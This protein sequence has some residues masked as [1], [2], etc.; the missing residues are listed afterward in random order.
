MRDVRT[1]RFLKGANII[2]KYDGAATQLRR[3]HLHKRDVKLLPTIEKH[4]INR[5]VDIGERFCRVA[6]AHVD[7]R[8]ETGGGDVLPRCLN[9]G[10][11]ELRTDYFSATVVANGGCQ[12]N[13]RDAEAGAE[14][15]DALGVDGCVPCCKYFAG[16]VRNLNEGIFQVRCDAVEQLLAARFGGERVRQGAQER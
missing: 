6:F 10:R 3:Q 13:R 1:Q 9:F 4:E 5:P 12:I 16:V 7:K 2:G 8:F 11:F 15:D 14:L